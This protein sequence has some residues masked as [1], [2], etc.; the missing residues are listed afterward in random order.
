MITRNYAVRH[1]RRAFAAPT[2]RSWLRS[3]A[4]QTTP[5]GRRT[6]VEDPPAPDRAPQPLPS[7]VKLQPSS[8][9]N[10]SDDT[11]LVR[12]HNPNIPK[13]LTNDVPNDFLTFTRLQKA[14]AGLGSVVDK[15]YQPGDLLKDP[16]SPKDITLELLM[17]SQAHMGHNTA[18][19]NPANARY[20]YGVRQG[21]HIISLEQT[22]AHLRRAARVVEEVAY[23]GGLILFVGTR[24]GQMEIVTRAAELAGACHLFT[25]WTPGTI[26]NRDQILVSQALKMVDENDQPLQGFNDHLNDCRP[27]AP[28]LV[29]CLNPLENFVMLREC[30]LEGVPTIGI[31]DTD[32]DPTKVTY[33]IPANDDS[34]RTVAVIGGVLGRAA[35]LGNQRRRREAKQGVVTWESPTDVK[36]FVALETERRAVAAAEAAMEAEQ[37]QVR[38]KTREHE[39]MGDLGVGLGL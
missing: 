28:D 15:H 16:P 35:Q 2:T 12:Y 25:K 38:E 22:A 5:P 30:A 8:P 11:V 27:L 36:K 7:S 19:W 17:A 39:I 18:R 10:P 24:K 13:P 9:S 29:V 31:I 23:R 14:T 32:A 33:Q 3:L 37:Q 4:T 20:I 1:G 6:A 26:T 21:I 34:L